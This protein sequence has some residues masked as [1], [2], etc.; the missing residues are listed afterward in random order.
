MDIEREMLRQIRSTPGRRKRDAEDLGDPIGDDL[1][2]A[3]V[4]D[5]RHQD[6]EPQ[7]VELGHSVAPANARPQPVGQFGQHAMGVGTGQQRRRAAVRLAQL[8]EHQHGRFIVALR[9]GDFVLD[10]IEK[11][12]A[13]RKAGH[14]VVDRL[15]RGVVAH[16]RMQAA[17]DNARN[18]R[19]QRTIFLDDLEE[20]VLGDAQNR[21][22]AL[23]PDR[24]RARRVA[25]QRELAKKIALAQGG[26]DF[27]AVDQVD[28]NIDSA[29]Q[30]H[31]GLIADVPLNDDI[32][33]GPIVEPLAGEGNQLEP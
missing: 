30:N 26:N 21:G 20:H 9:A 31:V 10:P 14:I 8:D 33:V 1:D 11:E 5:V 12:P 24:R 2:V 29:V 15:T 27:G 32:L 4:L 28:D 16:R 7:T 6:P 23:G 3:R 19:A 13:P 22:V 17:G 25:K 18:V